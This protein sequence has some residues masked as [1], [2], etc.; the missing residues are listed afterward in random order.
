MHSATFYDVPHFYHFLHL[1]LNCYFRNLGMN[2]W[3]VDRELCQGTRARVVVSYHSNMCHLVVLFIFTL[4]YSALLPIPHTSTFCTLLYYYYSY[5]LHLPYTYPHSA[6]PFSTQLHSNHLSQPTLS[7]H[8]TQ[9]R[10]SIH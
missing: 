8:P 7:Q 10:F 2:C 5:S 1:R 3:W 6:Y 4:L 9:Q